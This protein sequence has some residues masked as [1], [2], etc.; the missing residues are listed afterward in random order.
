MKEKSARPFALRPGERTRRFQTLDRKL[1]TV[2]VAGTQR[3]TDRRRQPVLMN[4]W[5]Y[6]WRTEF[7]ELRRG[8][9]VLGSG[10]VDEATADGATI[11]IHLSSGLGR[12]MIHYGDG[13][14]IW[15]VDSRILQD[16]SEPRTSRTSD[17]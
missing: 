3:L 10:R 11:W 7:V 17:R 1:S 15:R 5:N 12:V 13:T 9:T 2:A 16:R 6:L 14:D 8:F 4:D